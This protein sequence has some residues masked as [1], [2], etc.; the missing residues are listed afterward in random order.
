MEAERLFGRPDVEVLRRMC[1]GVHEV[2]ACEECVEHGRCGNERLYEAAEK[3]TTG[4]DAS[5]PD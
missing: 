2:G 4:D 3:E 5:R 1:C